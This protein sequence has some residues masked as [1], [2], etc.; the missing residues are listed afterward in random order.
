MTVKIM[1]DLER[2]I[3]LY[4]SFGINL[5]PEYDLTK[6]RMFVDLYDET[7]YKIKRFFGMSIVYFTVDGKFIYQVV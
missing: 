1:T 5:L 7:K 3:E 6:D 4:K 2:F